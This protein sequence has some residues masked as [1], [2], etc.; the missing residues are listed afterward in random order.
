V[1]SVS[2][3]ERKPP[4]KPSIPDELLILPSGDAVLYPSMIVPLS[5]GDEKTVKLIDEAVAGD[6]MV[7]LFARRPGEEQK[8]YDV[9]TAATIAKMFKMPDGSTNALIQ[10]LQRILSLY[11]RQL[12]N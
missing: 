12:K 9:G 6:K 2:E 5:T 10:G 3:E 1:I 8:L 11:L 7:A 4:E